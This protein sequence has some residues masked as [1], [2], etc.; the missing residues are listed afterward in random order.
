[1]VASL[2]GSA[3][4]PSAMRSDKEFKVY[5]KAYRQAMKFFEINKRFPLE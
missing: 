1:M 2:P 5:K 4:W 3:V